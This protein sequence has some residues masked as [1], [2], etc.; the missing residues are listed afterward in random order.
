MRSVCSRTS[1][2]AIIMNMPDPRHAAATAPAAS[3]QAPQWGGQAPSVI[4]PALVAHLANAF[5]M[6][7]QVGAGPAGSG[8]FRR[9][10]GTP[11]GAADICARCNR[12]GHC[13]TWNDRPW[14][15]AS[16]PFY[17][18]NPR[19]AA[20]PRVS[21]RNIFLQPL[22][23]R[24]HGRAGGRCRAARQRSA[25]WSA[26]SRHALRAK[27]FRYA[28]SLASSANAWFGDGARAAHSSTRILSI[29]SF[30]GTTRRSLIFP[31]CGH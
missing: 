27:L 25:F 12:R 20:H 6:P 16:D 8:E 14:C 13:H 3:P 24:H 9:H 5:S 21:L 4:D 11:S 31:R 28:R 17:D 29:H 2:S 26:E 7:R 10:A 19:L 18:R 1:K 30:S 22:C 15:R 23:L